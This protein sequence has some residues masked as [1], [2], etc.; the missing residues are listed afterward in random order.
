MAVYNSAGIEHLTLNTNMSEDNTN[1]DST[2]DVLSAL[3][4][5]IIPVVTIIFWL[6]GQV[7]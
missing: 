7:G 3:A 1:S 6:S 5:I 4:L 2:A